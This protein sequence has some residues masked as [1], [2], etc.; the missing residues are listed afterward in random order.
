MNTTTMTNAEIVTAA[1]EAEKLIAAVRALARTEINL[2]LR[3][4]VRARERA[5]T[6]DPFAI[7]TLDAKESRFIYGPTYSHPLT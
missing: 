1:D 4:I 2:R 7:G 6:G 5:R 3:F